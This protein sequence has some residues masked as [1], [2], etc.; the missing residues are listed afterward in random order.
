SGG[1]KNTILES[2]FLCL[3]HYFNPNLLCS[4]L[5]VLLIGHT[6]RRLHYFNAH[7]DRLG[8]REYRQI[9]CLVQGMME[10]VIFDHLHAAAFQGHPLGDTIL[11]PEENIRSISKKDLEQYIS[12]HYTCP[13]MVVS[14]AGSVSHDE[15]VDQVK[16]LF[17]EFSTDPTT[18]D[19]LVQA[20]PAIFTGSEVRVENAEF[21][22]AHIAIAFKGS[23]WTDPSS[24]PLMVIQSILGSWN[25]SIGVGNCSGSSLARGISNANLAESLM[26]FNTNYRDTGIFGI[27]TIAPPDTL[28]DLSRLIMAEFRRLASQVSETEVARA[29]NQ[30]KS[31][32]LLH[33]DGSTAV[34][35]NNGRQMLT[36]GRVMPFLELFARIDA[37][38]CATVMETAKEYIIDK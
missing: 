33:I 11:G 14:A 21:P 17:T 8:P 31:S 25:R 19:Q 15:V 3:K 38:D 22:L 13:R 10:E 18:A 6:T 26:A 5:A 24:I 30:L 1:K 2:L 36:Y 4:I 23:S 28:Q 29:R 27:Y 32:L 12:T 20:N 34:T 37:V 7:L 16:E 9:Y 35:E